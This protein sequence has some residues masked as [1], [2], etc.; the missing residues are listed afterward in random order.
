MAISSKKAR[1]KVIS[2][3]ALLALLVALLPAV[4]ALA[5]V[6]NVTVVAD[7]TA[8]GATAEYEVAF[9]FE[10]DGLATG[11][12]VTITFPAGFNPQDAQV[13]S[14]VYAVYP[15]AWEVTPDFEVNHPTPRVFQL[16]YTGAGIP[17]N[18]TVTVTISGV[19]NPTTAGDY[20]I[21]VRTSHTGDTGQTGTVTIVPAAPASLVIADESGTP[22]ADGTQV[23]A[24]TPQS[25]VVVL[26]DQHGNLGA[27]AAEGITVTLSDNDPQANFEGEQETAEATIPQNASESEQVT[28]T[29]MTAGDITITATASG[30]ESGSVTFEVL[31]GEPAALELAGPSYLATNT[32]GTYTITLRDDFGNV[33]PAG[34][35]GV[36]VTLA[37]NPA[38]GAEFSDAQGNPLQ[39]NQLTV[40]Q[41]QSSAQFRF[42]STQANLYTVTASAAGL[43]QD[44]ITVA[45]GV[46]VLTALDITAPQTGEV[47][48]ASEIAITLKD[49]F[50]NNFAAPQ[51]GVTIDLDTDSDGTFYDRPANGS[52][53]NEVTVPQGQSS[54]KV[55]YVPAPDAVGA[56]TLTFA[57]PRV[58]STGVLLGDTVTAGATINVGTG[59]E[60]RLD[61]DLPTFTV[62]GRGE[63]TITVRDVFSNPV[64]A[65]QN[66]RVVYL[67]TNSPTGA[68]YLTATN[69]NPI[70]QVTIPAGSVSATIYYVDTGSW[71]KK[72]FEDGKLSAFGLNPA[73]YSYTVAF[74]SEGV[75][76]F[77]G[78]AIVDPAEATAITLD[79]VHQ[80]VEAVP[81]EVFTQVGSQIDATDLIG[82]A[83]IIVVVVDQYGNPVPQNTSLLISLK[84]DSPSAFLVPDCAFFENDMWAY[85]DYWFVVTA[86]GTYTVT[87]SAGGFEAVSKQVVFEE[88]SL[89]IDAPAAALPDTRVPVTVRL[90][91]LWASCRALTVDLATSTPNSAFYAD[92]Q[93]AEPI[94]QA[95]IPAYNDEVT[96]YLESDDPLGT[97]V[98]LTAEIADLDLTAEAT[99]FIGRGPDLVTPLF[100]GWNIISTPWALADGRDTI[101]ESLENPEYVEQAWGY[102]DGQWYQV[103]PANPESM[104]LRP[105][106]A[107]YVKVK[108][109]TR[110]VSCAQPGLG[111]PPM[112]GLPAGWN[113][114]GNPAD[115]GMGANEALSSISGSYAV[116]ISPAGCNQPAWVYTPQTPNPENYVMMDFRGY[117]VYMRQADTLA[118]LAMPPVQ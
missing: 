82:F 79:G 81:D 87:A 51:G 43:T 105:L 24:G 63:V 111:T 44:Q 90:T 96:V 9:G 86:P 57:A 99:I 64:P 41:G 68:F 109:Q 33:A 7:D 55:Y 108:G 72:A 49:Q 102:K 95:I 46:T 114:V 78:Q 56:H 58:T 112:R 2:I 73:D 69:Q 76:G 100:R 88:P 92:D 107:L 26:A 53:I 8:A 29:P 91:N 3:I 61:V 35:G 110:A 12:S 36:T 62:G 60:L 10:S 11:D 28:W 25:L 47:G 30:L 54:I 103:T 1:R 117:W 16:F 34:A 97:G 38:Q 27:V 65:G 50:G 74:R 59:A 40:P 22:I 77:I 93:A 115:Q 39:N 23:T 42:R 104:K 116:V 94:T 37:A 20:N 98:E 80:D 21:T 48:I 89:V 118:G 18:S 106:E 67:E 71:T 83:T 66:G 113:L 84:D 14:V 13:T 19:V 52:D 31:P 15:D 85:T 6:G 70:T 75:F 17:E 45:V 4:P 5:H 101:D 32:W